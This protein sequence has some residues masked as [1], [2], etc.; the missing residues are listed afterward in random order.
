MVAVAPAAPRR[1]GFVNIGDLRFAVAAEGGDRRR[2]Q[3]SCCAAVAFAE[4]AVAEVETVR[5]RSLLGVVLERSFFEIVTF[6][7]Q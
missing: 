2:S 3:S 4:E 1:G 6:F 5:E 7:D